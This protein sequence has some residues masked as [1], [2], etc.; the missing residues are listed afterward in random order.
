MFNLM[1][2]TYEQLTFKIRQEKR[3]CLAWNPVMP[4]I[5]MIE[6]DIVLDTRTNPVMIASSDTAFAA[7][8]QE[9]VSRMSIE[10]LSLQN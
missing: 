9:N 8:T 2:L 3:R 7:A 1:R 4:F 10:I 6:E 5:A